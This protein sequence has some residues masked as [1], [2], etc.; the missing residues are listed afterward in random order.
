MDNSAQSRLD[1]KARSNYR[2]SLFPVFF[3]IIARQSS[4]GSCY[5]ARISADLKTCVTG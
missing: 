2:L 5:K 3:L 1:I 4:L